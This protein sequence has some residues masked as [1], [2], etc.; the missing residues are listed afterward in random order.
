MPYLYRHIRLDTDTPF[1]IGIG[2]DE[3]FRRAYEKTR[4]NL[5]WNNITAKTDYEVEILLTDLTWDEACL[6]EKEFISLYGRQDQGLGSLVNYTD[7]GDGLHNPSV[8]IRERK[9][10]SMLGKNSGDKNG[11]KNQEARSK[12]SASRKGKFTGAESP[13]SKAVS[14]YDL[15]GTLV[16]SYTSVIEAERETGA[17]NPNITKVCKGLRKTAGN[18]IWKYLN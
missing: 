5:H 11:M 17:L 10:A 13:V 16:K 8:E 15:Q 12:V 3:S 7:G 2:S 18:Y 6:K 1:Y 4:R 9:R 14:C